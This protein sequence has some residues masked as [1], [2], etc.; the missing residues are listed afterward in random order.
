MKWPWIT[1]NWKQLLGQVKEKWGKSADDHLT[2]TAGKEHQLVGKLQERYGYEKDQ[3]EM[4][5]DK[6]SRESYRLGATGRRRPVDLE[7]S[8][9]KRRRVARE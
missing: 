1:G 3:T 5:L 4:E 6:F 7:C 2:S 9:D 8:A